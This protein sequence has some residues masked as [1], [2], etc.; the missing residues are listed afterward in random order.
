[1]NMIVPIGLLTPIM[2]DLLSYGRVN[3]PA[4]PWLGVY[5]TEADDSIV[6]FDV[7][8]L[9]KLNVFDAQGHI[10]DLAWIPGSPQIIFCS[11]GQAYRLD[12]DTLEFEPLA[13][14]AELCACHPHLPL[15]ICFNSWLKNSATGRLF[16]ADLNRQV[17]FD[18]RTADGVVDLCWSA[19]GTKAFAITQDGLGYVYE[20]PLL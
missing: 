2:K 14:G 11:A 12:S 8:S 9:D 20:P 15:C 3:R 17:I 13:F 1:M 4:R 10:T 7:P 19:D 6:V 18:Q 16:L 5:A